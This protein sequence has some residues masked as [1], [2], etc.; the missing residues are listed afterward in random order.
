[1]RAPHRGR[2]Y[3]ATLTDTEDATKKVLNIVETNRFKNVTHLSL[4]L[5]RAQDADMVSYLAARLHQVKVTGAEVQNQLDALQDAHSR[6][7]DRLASTEAALAS[8]QSASDSTTATLKVT[9]AAELSKVREEAA[10]AAEAASQRHAADLASAAKEARREL[11]SLRATVDEGATQ[12]AALERQVAQLQA[13]LRDAQREGADWRG[14]AEAAEAELVSHRSAAEAAGQHRVAQ[15][16]DLSSS[17]L[18]VAA[19]E[20]QVADGQQLLQAVRERLEAEVSAHGRTSD[21]LALY[22]TSFGKLQGKLNTSISEIEKG[23]RIITRLKEDQRVLRAKVKLH[24]SQAKQA[25]LTANARADDLR[26]ALADV[27]DAKRR[28]GDAESLQEQAQAKVTTL[29]EQLEEARGII[30]RN[31]AVIDHLNRAVNELEGQ[32]FSRP[33]TFS[34][35]STF[36]PSR[37]GASRHLHTSFA[38]T[39]NPAARHDTARAPEPSRPPQPLPSSTS[40][41]ADIAARMAARVATMADSLRVGSSDAGQQRRNGASSDAADRPAP[42][43][44]AGS[45][46]DTTASTASPRREGA[47]LTQGERKQAAALAGLSSLLGDTHKPAANHAY[48]TSDFFGAEEEDSEPPSADARHPPAAGPRTSMRTVDS[49]MGSDSAPHMHLAAAQA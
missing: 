35:A 23:N 3:S 45:A 47:P 11:A 39:P 7:A 6:M 22:K 30:S 18:R 34:H 9:H 19:L 15:E 43:A 12:R 2:R 37:T 5:S 41:P 1:M 32:R 27:A 13:D 31:T 29:T 46:V 48:F 44:H 26:R 21:S 16:K 49:S 14:K 10:M 8:A 42:H 36:T 38:T 4:P 25:E 28:A 24:A 33:G 40:P 17:T 20:Q